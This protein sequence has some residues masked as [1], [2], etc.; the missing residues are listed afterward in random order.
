M[1][2]VE[3]FLEEIGRHYCARATCFHIVDQIMG[4]V[5]NGQFLG[6]GILSK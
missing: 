5:G 2:E 1:E 3:H 4:T 6:V